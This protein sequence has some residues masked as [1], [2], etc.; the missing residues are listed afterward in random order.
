MAST[1]VGSITVRG[2]NN[3]MIQAS[4]A[5]L[6]SASQVL[7]DML[8]GEN[9]HEDSDQVLDMSDATETE[10]QAFV[11]LCGMVSKQPSRIASRKGK[12]RTLLSSVMAGESMA[13]VAAAMPLIHKYEA[14][15][16]MALFWDL[17]DT[18]PDLACVLA[19]EKAS[20]DAVVWSDAILKH[21]VDSTMGVTI[22][23]SPPDYD[24]VYEGAVDRAAL[25]NLRGETLVRVLAF[26]NSSLITTSNGK[27]IEQFCHRKNK[28]KG[29]VA[30]TEFPSK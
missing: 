9:F 2:A 12:E 28:S 27:S 18:Q 29:T 13:T 1:M 7:A 15:G 19:Y 3:V 23:E 14:S 24:Q 20:E 4:M 5:V 17:M 30:N 21:I 6:A 8:A 25:A 26:I 11:A 10:V 22:T 16:L